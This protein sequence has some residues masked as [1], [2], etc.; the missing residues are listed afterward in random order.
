MRAKPLLI[1]SV[2]QEILDVLPIESR[3]ILSILS[4]ADRPVPWQVLARAASHDGPP[5][6][7][8]IDRGLMLELEDGMWLHE[9]IR[10]RLL[11]DVGRPLEERLRRLTDASDA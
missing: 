6:G 10:T 1:P 11:R 2:D 8:L 3:E 5:P 9:A 4:V 7:D